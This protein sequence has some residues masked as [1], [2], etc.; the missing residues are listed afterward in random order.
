MNGLVWVLVP[1]TGNYVRGDEI[2]EV[3]T[4]DAG[5]GGAVAVEI[6][7]VRGDDRERGA[8]PNSYPLWTLPD[9]SVAATA[10]VRLM[11]ALSGPKPGVVLID[12]DNQV[13]LLSFAEVEGRQKS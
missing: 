3:R 10:A 1:K 2:V 4:I 7:Q 11:E 13:R 9:E 12:D 5:R 8:G 6:T